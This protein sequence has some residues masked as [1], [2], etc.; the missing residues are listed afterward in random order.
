MV[1]SG[2]VTGEGRPI[3]NA[4]VQLRT[5][6]NGLHFGGANTDASGRYRVEIGGLLLPDEGAPAWITAYHPE[7]DLQP[8]AVFLESSRE[9]RTADVILGRQPLRAPPPPA[10]GRR[11]ISG[12]VYRQTAGGKRAAPDVWVGWDLINDDFKAWTRTD[13]GG[14]FTLCQVLTNIAIGLFAHMEPRESLFAWQTVQPGGDS[15][16]ELTLA[17]LN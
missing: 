10:S 4:A 11:T 5:D 9:E 2:T 15:E 14:R 8:C 12:T 16:V 17:P 1:V 6:V 7:F 13:D 3:A